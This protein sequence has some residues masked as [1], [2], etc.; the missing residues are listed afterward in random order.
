MSELKLI[1]SGE[2]IEQIDDYG[3]LA[4]NWAS[5]REHAAVIRLPSAGANVAH[6]DPHGM[7]L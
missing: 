2:D 4:L 7:P 6:A 1:D 3:L 5:G